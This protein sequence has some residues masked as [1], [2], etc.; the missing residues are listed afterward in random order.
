MK[1]VCNK[2]KAGKEE[3]KLIEFDSTEDDDPPIHSFYVTSGEFGEQADSYIQ[4]S[5][6]QIKVYDRNLNEKWTYAGLNI[7]HV[8]DIH[9]AYLYTISDTIATGFY[10]TDEEA[11]DGPVKKK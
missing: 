6:K 8:F 10:V 4:I 11:E 9:Q 2:D 5:S 7:R 1:L 3:P